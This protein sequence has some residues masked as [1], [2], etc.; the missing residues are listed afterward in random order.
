MLKLPILE[1]YIGYE[2]LRIFLVIL[3]VLS[4]ILLGGSL[5][6]MLKL[7]A[8]G[9]IPTDSVATLIF[10]EL[11]RL[12]GRLI[13][14]AFFFAAVMALGR[15]Y[16]D[17]EMTVLQSSGIGMNRIRRVILMMGIPV[18]LVSAWLTLWVYPVSARIADDLKNQHQEAVLLA[19]M[20]SG[21][22][23]EARGGKLVFYAEQAETGSGKLG[24]VF[25]QVRKT[26]G[27]SLVTA[28]SGKHFLNESTGLRHVVLYKGREYNGQPGSNDYSALH[29]DEYE[30]VIN[31]PEK[32]DRRVDLNSMD[33]LDLIRKGNLTSSVELQ[34][35]LLFPLSVIAF[36]LLAIPLSRSSPRKSSYLNVV[37]AVVSYLVFMAL[38]KSADKWMLFGMTPDWMGLWWILV[39]MLVIAAMIEGYNGMRFKQVRRNRH[40]AA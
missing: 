29:F 9:T 10:L 6:K 39:L 32:Q 22:F 25:I 40:A 19:A 16:Q 11:L 1:R 21:R 7:A 36:G 4:L 18:A 37:M 31:A 34:S 5:V 24:N 20:G 14:A 38:L 17:Q 8:S 2:I 13:P 30:I 23:Y 3:V 12:G 26:D 15:M 28:E 27:V 33:S 35:R